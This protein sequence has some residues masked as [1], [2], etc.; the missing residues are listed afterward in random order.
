[1]FTRT[2][3]HSNLG[4]P[5]PP[6][7]SYLLIVVFFRTLRNTKQQPLC[8]E[9]LFSAA[10][11]WLFIATPLQLWFWS[12]SSEPFF[13]EVFRLPKERCSNLT[14]WKHE[15]REHKVSTGLDSPQSRGERNAPTH[16]ARA[17]IAP[18]SSRACPRF[19]L[20]QCHLMWTGSLQQLSCIGY[21]PQMTL[22]PSINKA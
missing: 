13:S 8:S 22:S 9:Q 10:R 7:L 15:D 1:M 3:H 2:D 4:I 5:P 6:S 16:M 21:W 19:S 17:E 11:A 18:F 20:Q 12:I 14:R